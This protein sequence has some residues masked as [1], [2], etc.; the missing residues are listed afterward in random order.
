MK[1]IEAAIDTGTFV[2]LDSPEQLSK[3]GIFFYIKNTNGM[4]EKTERHMGLYFTIEGCI[5]IVDNTYNDTKRGVGATR[6]QTVENLFDHLKSKHKC[7]A[8]KKRGG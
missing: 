1:Y 7:S 8:L 2:E 3:S 4:N 5:R 6:F